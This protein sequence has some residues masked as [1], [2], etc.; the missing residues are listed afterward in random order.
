MG[1]IVLAGSDRKRCGGRI[2]L[3]TRWVGPLVRRLGPKAQKGGGNLGGL[4]CIGPPMFTK[5]PSESEV[6]Q[7]D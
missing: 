3:G 7:I 6:M 1:D 2:W 5:K 4:S